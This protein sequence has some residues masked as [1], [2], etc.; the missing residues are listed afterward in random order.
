MAARRKRRVNDEEA[1]RPLVVRHA[2]PSGGR[3]LTGG[4]LTHFAGNPERGERT[5]DD[6]R[7]P[8][9]GPDGKRNNDDERKPRYKTELLIR[10]FFG[11]VGA[12]PTTDPN[13]VF[14]ESPDIWIDGPSGDPDQATPGVLNTVNVHVWNVGLADCWAAHI[15]LYWCDPSV[16][17]SP[18]LAHPIGSTVIN[19]M[20]GAHA[21][22]PFPWVP[23]SANG[24]H[25][26]LVAQ[27]YD[28]VSDPIVAP[29]S[30]TLDRHVGQRNISVVEAAPGRTF[31]F[32]FEVSNLTMAAVSPTLS[33]QLLTGASRNRF[34]QT[35]GA[36]KW[37]SLGQLGPATL[38]SL[39]RREIPAGER[40][41]E[42][43]TGAVRERLDGEPNRTTLRRV[44]GGLRALTAPRGRAQRRAPFAMAS[45]ELRSRPDAYADDIGAAERSS[46]AR[47]FAGGVVATPPLSVVHV[48][49]RGRAAKTA[50]TDGRDVY[51]VVERINGRVTGGVTVIIK[52]PKR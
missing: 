8:N 49:V 11:D 45:W 51:R 43:A 27:V 2:L 1:V 38:V 29:F 12:R 13:L 28:P 19:L 6:R 47:G 18:A 33:V 26:C 36:P 30:P 42:R 39:G 23:S 25:E 16:G 20:G 37:R 46:R 34:L 9:F 24:G 50:K 35:I 22:V 44:A 14:W 31:Q 7:N 40:I 21:V 15:D 10:T 32:D 41:L 4:L 3:L 17:I 52:A 5:P 48:A